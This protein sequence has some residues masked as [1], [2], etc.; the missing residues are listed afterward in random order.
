MPS[1]SQIKTICIDSRVS[2][3]VKFILQEVIKVSYKSTSKIILNISLIA[4]S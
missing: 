2:L 3:V 1:S 4:V